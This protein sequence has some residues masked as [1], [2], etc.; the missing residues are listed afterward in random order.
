[1]ALKAELMQQER[2]WW[3]REDYKAVE[4]IGEFKNRSD[5]NNNKYGR[6]KMTETVGKDKD[7]RITENPYAKSTMGKCF[8]CNQPG[9]KS[10]KCPL[11]KTVNIVEKN[12]EII[13]EPDGD[14]EEEYEA[15][16]G[17]FIF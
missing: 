15:E 4:S 9:H 10:N 16:K 1:M 3:N 13:C 8:K 17:K 12:E 7:V 11:R 6:N 2:S 14:E 5:K